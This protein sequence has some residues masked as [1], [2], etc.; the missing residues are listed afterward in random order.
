VEGTANPSVHCRCLYI[1]KRTMRVATRRADKGVR[2][3]IPFLFAK[4]IDVFKAEGESCQ[5]SPSRDWGSSIV[6][7]THTLGTEYLYIV[8]EAV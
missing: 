3:S 1:Q 6:I 2:R 8:R 5:F 4:Q 7:L